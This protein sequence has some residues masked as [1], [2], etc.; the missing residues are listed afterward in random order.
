MPFRS[1]DGSFFLSSFSLRV[2]SGL[3]LSER[4][5]LFYQH[6]FGFG[7]HGVGYLKLRW[8]SRKLRL[9]CALDIDP[10]GDPEPACDFVRQFFPSTFQACSC[11]TRTGY[12]SFTP[13][14][15][16]TCCVDVLGQ[17]LCSNRRL[18]HCRPPLACPTVSRV[19]PSV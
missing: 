10:S 5:T 3:S 17:V 4:L 7:F 2:P 9:G 11:I 1:W 12:L 13:A 16:M 18:S 14:N 8:Y 19:A 6:G 15:S